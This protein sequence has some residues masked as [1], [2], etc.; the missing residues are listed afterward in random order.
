MVFAPGENLLNF[1]NFKEIKRIEQG[2]E[3]K[4]IS[5]HVE[6]GALATKL[7]TIEAGSDENVEDLYEKLSNN[8]IN[9]ILS[10]LEHR[11][12]AAL[13]SKVKNEDAIVAFMAP[14][15]S[16]FSIK[17]LN[18]KYLDPLLTDRVIKERKRLLEELFTENLNVLEQEFKQSFF[19]VKKDI[20]FNS[21]E[22]QAWMQ[23]QMQ[24][25]EKS[26]NNFI[27]QL[28]K[29]RAQTLNVN[30]DTE[31]AKNIAFLQAKLENVLADPEASQFLDQED[32]YKITYGISQV[33]SQQESDL[34]KSLIV[35]EVKAIQGS[36][37]S[38][39][40]EGKY[41]AI[42]DK[43]EI[44]K[45]LSRLEEL[46]SELVTINKLEIPGKLTY[47]LFE[48]KK[49]EQGGFSYLKLN[50]DLWT[51]LRKGKLKAEELPA[52]SHRI[53]E[54]LAE[55]KELVNS[56]DYFKP[57]LAEEIE[58]G[59][60]VSK[61]ET[62]QKIAGKVR[63]REV[64]NQEEFAAVKN[65]MSHDIKDEKFTSEG[66]FH[67]NALQINNCSYISL[68]VLGLGSDLLGDYEKN[69]A[70]M[71]HLGEESWDTILFNV[72]DDVTRRMRDIRAAAL[73]VFHEF[74]IDTLNTKVGGDEMTFALENDQVTDALLARLKERT[75]SR[76]VKTVLSEVNKKIEKPESDA[77]ALFHHIEA[78]GKC[79]KAIN[80]IKDAE[81]QWDRLRNI[82]QQKWGEN[83]DYTD[84][85]Q[86]NSLLDY[87]NEKLFSFMQ[88]RG[89]H[90]PD[91]TKMFIRQSDS[92]GLF[93][94][95]EKRDS[96]ENEKPVYE[97]IEFEDFLE[98]FTK[99]LD[100]EMQS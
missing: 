73:E 59:T 94:V 86:V 19:I 40:R 44:K 13:F 80:K 29:E 31:E 3:Y 33:R 50:K 55:Y 12:K 6:A 5:R 83:V 97:L 63:N 78:L 38:R 47:L 11:G 90:L 1:N 70:M 53:L 25:L 100:R 37:Q 60:V 95:S 64:L 24:I 22:F 26:M 30:K 48:S 10:F 96:A 27:L 65:L 2:E 69:L 14:S 74:G 77:E 75:N 21:D 91:F 71:Q 39:V 17:S 54:L 42:F 41:G 35:A 76:V 56:I 67:Y 82:L 81:N 9:I 49:D 99:A 15:G 52:Q 88:T 45:N 84:P 28:L 43:N 20:D 34:P 57:Y 8:E 58:D 51:A 79:D 46:R 4:R 93:L 18:D 85:E 72:G 32:S 36:K 87:V 98:K 68:D 7:E 23:R 66:L 62:R 92:N 16:T 61:L 89:I